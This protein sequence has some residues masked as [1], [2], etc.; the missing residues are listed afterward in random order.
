MGFF[1]RA[2]DSFD[3]AKMGLEMGREEQRNLP[4]TTEG[5]NARMDAMLA[6]QQAAL[7]YAGRAQRLA[8]AGVDVLG[9]VKQA[10]LSEQLGSVSA[11]LVITVKPVG[12]QPYDVQFQQAV[13]PDA[14]SSLVAG[15][16]CTVR[17]DPE[18]PEVAMLYS[19]GPSWTPPVQSAPLATAASGAGSS[20][21]RATPQPAP[22]PSGAASAADMMDR[23]SKLADLHQQ[24]LITDDEFAK[25]KAE[26]LGS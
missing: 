12:G 4:K 5:M 16:R 7:D 24:G 9:E 6:Q 25:R 2:K 18:D 1:R 22:A 10:V 21:T 15:A 23:V 13:R 20:A 3:V 14:A 17:V 19:W 11:A 26:I 8:T